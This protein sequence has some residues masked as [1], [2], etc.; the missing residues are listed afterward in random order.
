MVDTAHSVAFFFG[1]GASVEAGVPDTVGL[2]AKFRDITKDKNLS[3]FIT[4][5]E[6]WAANNGRTVDIELVLAILESISQW[7]DNPMSCVAAIQSL[8]K[9]FDAKTLL[10]ELRDFIK[11]EV[12]IKP[13][14]IQYLAPLRG[15]IS[16]SPGLR[17]FSANYD[18]AIELFCAEHK[19]RYRDGFDEAWNIEVFND[20]NIDLLLFKLHGSI[21]WYRSDRGRFLKIPI[22]TA[23]SSVEL[24]TRERAH[25]LMLYP[26]QKFDYVEPLFEL[27]LQ[28]KR[29]LANIRTLVVVGYTFRDEHIRRM[30]WDIARDNPE[31]NL[32]LIDPRA[33]DIYEK[34]LRNY[35][36]GVTRSS[37]NGRVVPLP[38]LFGKVFPYLQP[39]LLLLLHQAWES[40]KGL[41]RQEFQ[42][43]LADW[44]ET[45]RLAARAGNYEMAERIFRN[46]DSMPQLYYR[47]AFEIAAFG[48]FHAAANKDF[49]AQKQFW[50][51]LKQ[52]LTDFV[53]SF[54]VHVVIQNP[55]NAMELIFEAN[56]NARGGQIRM[57]EIVPKLTEIVDEITLRM[58]WLH[59]TLSDNHHVR[60]VVKLFGDLAEL[61]GI[62]NIHQIPFDTYLND[63]TR[64]EVMSD[65][66][67]ALLNGLKTHSSTVFDGADRKEELARLLQQLENDV[68]T[69]TL[70]N[71]YNPIFLNQ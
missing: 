5:L 68:L 61:W 64:K 20:K 46:P 22:L 32:V 19:L 60:G 1:A 16:A 3:E 57:Q 9:G 37:L 7:Q 15:F 4:Q 50:E 41:Q 67:S 51:A 63:P 44:E 29:E 24:V 52:I 45:A 33:K 6:E 39:T 47:T 2:I 25:L 71:K 38:F 31:F 23:D 30:F 28:S 8:P 26:A 36:D 40:A 66:L 27:L 10:L 49:P 11:S 69:V 54:L 12:L 34:R 58:K 55:Q 43:Q 42:G 14:K 13:E 35:E 62:L 48:L 53:E 18:T 65:I 59:P 56:R 70:F 17:V 21:T